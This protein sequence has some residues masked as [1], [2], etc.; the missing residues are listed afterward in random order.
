M[1][2][3]H[4]AKSRLKLDL[5][6]PPDDKITIEVANELWVPYEKVRQE[7]DDILKDFPMNLFVKH[8]SETL[9]LASTLELKQHHNQSEIARN[10]LLLLIGISTYENVL[11]NHSESETSVNQRPKE[12]KE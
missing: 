10:R 5:D 1:N 7:I 11:P 12:A 6:Y 4:I 2:L 3:K 9:D 8:K